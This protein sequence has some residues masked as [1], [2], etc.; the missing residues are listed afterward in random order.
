MQVTLYAVSALILAVGALLPVGAQ[1]VHVRHPQFTQHGLLT[2]RSQTGKFVASGDLITIAHGNEVHSRLALHFLDG[3]LDEEDTIYRQDGVFRLLRDHHIQKGPSY[4]HPVETVIDMATQQVTTRT[5][6]DGKEE[7]RTEHMD[8][9][10][11]LANGLCA[12]VLLNYPPGA[13]EIHVSYLAGGEKPRLVDLGIRPDGADHFM[14]GGL[15]RTSVRYN[16]HTSIGGVTGVVA[17]WLGK[18]PP[19]MKFWMLSGEVPQFL[20][21]DGPLSLDGPVWTLALAA[22]EWREEM[23]EAR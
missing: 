20:R 18:Q 21:F 9:P 12:N 7:T 10:A 5:W 13:P 17:Q 3:S 4:E 1:P 2:L 14:L 6:K 15:R 16:V 11:D 22:P 8:L 23:A 19:D